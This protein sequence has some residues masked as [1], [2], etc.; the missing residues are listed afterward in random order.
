MKHLLSLQWKHTGRKEKGQRR[1]ATALLL[2]LC[3]ICSHLVS[4][5]YAAGVDGSEISRTAESGPAADGADQSGDSSEAA[6]SGD[7]VTENSGDE[8]GPQGDTGAAKKPADTADGPTDNTGAAAAD[9][10]DNT[11]A[12]TVIVGANPSKVPGIGTAAGEYKLYITHVLTVDGYLFADENVEVSGGLTEEDLS[13]GY[14]VLQNAYARAGMAVT[15]QELTVTKDDFD[16]NKSCYMEIAYRVADGYKAVYTLPQIMTRSIYMGEID[17]VDLVPARTVEVKLEYKFHKSTGMENVPAHNYD[18]LVLE[19]EGDGNYLLRH[20]IPDVIGQTNLA[21]QNL[22]VVLDPAPLEALV[23]A[24]KKPGSEPIKRE[25]FEKALASSRTLVKTGTANGGP[26]N[27]VYT[28]D[29]ES[30]LLTASI[31]KEDRK[32]VV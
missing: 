7:G 17:D 2:C 9:G 23:P 22:W 32:S 25:D 20:Q 26:V 8:N 24:G 14:N 13:G 16:E 21:E 5:V 31:P 4:A 19:M 27:I 29:A 10:T 15:T 1:R 11:G 3:L 28:Y 12:G 18:Q 6:G 30:N